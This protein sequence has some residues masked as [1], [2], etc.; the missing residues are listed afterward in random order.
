MPITFTPRQAQI[1]LLAIEGYTNKQI[2]KQ[3]GLG[4]R[5]VMSHLSAAYGIT[6]ATNR[7]RL[8]A[9]LKTHPFKI[10]ETAQEQ[11]KYRFQQFTHLFSQGIALKHIAK[12]LEVSKNTVASYKQRLTA[13]EPN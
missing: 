7:T 11:S 3:L 13:N 6:G 4:E 5:T 2:A 1:A 10:K 9:I 8:M 12:T